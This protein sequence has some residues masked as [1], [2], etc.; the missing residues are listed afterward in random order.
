I[1]SLAEE[2]RKLRARLEAVEQN[3]KSLSLPSSA[4]AEY[5][6]RSVESATDELALLCSPEVE[7]LSTKRLD[8]IKR[9]IGATKSTWADLRQLYPPGQS[10]FAPR[11]DS[12]NELDAALSQAATMASYGVELLRIALNGTQ[13]NRRLTRQTS[14]L[15]ATLCSTLISTRDQ[16]R[17]PRDTNASSGREDKSFRKRI[18]LNIYPKPHRN[19]ERPNVPDT[20]NRRNRPDLR[21]TSGSELTD[22]DSD[23]LWQESRQPNAHKKQRT[24]NATPNIDSTTP[25]V[26]DP[27]RASDITTKVNAIG[28]SASASDADAEEELDL[29][30]G[31][32]Q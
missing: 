27:N 17:R 2:N 32:V 1:D 30:V 12:G 7:P 14:H 10:G 18:K 4:A 6:A 24:P 22:L 13:V 21:V 11:T 20:N 31:Q 29:V 26:C 28:N 23:Y 25:T 5:N 19:D 3:A 16:R 8:E 9:S 15:L